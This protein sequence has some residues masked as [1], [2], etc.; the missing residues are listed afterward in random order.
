MGKNN[1]N[2]NIR[3]KFGDLYWLAIDGK[4]IEPVIFNDEKTKIKFIL[5]GEIIGNNAELG[6][7]ELKRPFAFD[8]LE[9]NV[10]DEL[11][12]QSDY[13][14]DILNCKDFYCADFENICGG[15]LYNIKTHINTLDLLKSKIAKN[16]FDNES[17]A[18][19]NSYCTKYSL[20]DY[21]I[22]KNILNKKLEK[23]NQRKQNEKDNLTKSANLVKDN[24][25][26]TKF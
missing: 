2:P 6:K 7:A 11:M 9:D 5:T 22:F 3:I 13:V 19:R 24:M 23:I 16:F 4:H 15:F 21:E 10:Q 25:D 8:T 26:F 12:Q 20:R 14:K 17:R 1:Y 18:D